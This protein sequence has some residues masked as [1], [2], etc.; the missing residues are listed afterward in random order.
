VYS[1]ARFDLHCSTITNMIGPVR[2]RNTVWHNDYFFTSTQNTV[3]M[4]RFKID[5][6]FRFRILFFAFSFYSLQI[7]V[8]SS[9][10]II[11]VCVTSTPIREDDHG[12]S[13]FF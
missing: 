2:V 7:K 6:I 9:P 13:A 10:S 11:I 5:S 8:A 3:F 1:R 4:T 12:V